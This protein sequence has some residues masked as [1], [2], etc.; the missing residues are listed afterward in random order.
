MTG[1]T[2]R[3]R[4]PQRLTIA[5]LVQLLDSVC[6]EQPLETRAV[7]DRITSRLGEVGAAQAFAELIADGCQAQLDR[8]APTN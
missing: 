6:D 5:E 4:W 8:L 7:M 3:P 1:P 2:P